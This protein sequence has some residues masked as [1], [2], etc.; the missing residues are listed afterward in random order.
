MSTK[1]KL[2]TSTL[3]RWRESVLTLVK[4]KYNKFKQKIQPKKTKPV[5]CNTDAI[6]YLEAL[7][8]GFAVVT[9]DEA[10]NNFY[11]QKILCL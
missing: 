3:A 2:E 7:R 6:S 5:L 1:N 10:E 11:L 9:I 4:E 8:K